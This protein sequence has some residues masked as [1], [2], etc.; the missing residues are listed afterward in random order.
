M[1]PFIPHTGHAGRD[2][3]RPYK[4]SKTRMELV[5]ATYN[6]GKL[7]ELQA[8]LQNYGFRLLSLSDFPGI[9]EA[10]EDG[11]SFSEIALKKA[12]FY[13]E[14]T[15]SAVLAEDSGLVIP[16][17]NGYPGI[18]SAR[19]GDTDAERIRIILEK[20][21]VHKDRSAYY[22]CSMVYLSST[23][24]LET[25]GRCDGTITDAPRG[26]LGFGYDP[27]FQ[28]ENTDRTFAEMT[29]AEKAPL[30]H[31]GRA[32]SQMIALLRTIS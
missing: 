28:P 32:L 5:I 7:R 10:P 14:Q 25:T 22:H 12:Q 19:I 17:L 9:P 18:F 21:K 31:R 1:A 29:V 2:K 30:S 11:D 16:V 4:R 8:G 26:N 24:Q 6:A 23:H 27:I 13:A 20:M 15:G 3:S